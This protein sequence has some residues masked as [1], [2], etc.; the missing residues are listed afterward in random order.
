MS[1]ADV[2]AQRHPAVHETLLLAGANAVQH[3]RFPVA[4][5]PTM[6]TA[7]RRCLDYVRKHDGVFYTRSRDIAEWTLQRETKAAR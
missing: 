6:A 2:D 3:L 7:I 5:R 1:R 4:G